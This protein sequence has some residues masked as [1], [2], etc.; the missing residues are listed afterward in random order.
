[1]TGASVGALEDTVASSIQGGRVC[2][3]NRQGQNRSPRQAREDPTGASIGALEHT[4][5]ACSGVKRRWVRRVN[6]Q[7]QNR[8]PRQARGDPTGASI[9][10]LEHTAPEI[11]PGV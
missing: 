1:P 7:G 8:S 9:G 5:F 2:R 10:A 6:R 11:L 4:A 3:V